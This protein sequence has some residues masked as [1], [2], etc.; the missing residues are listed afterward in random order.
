MQTSMY[1]KVGINM[2]DYI[3]PEI[4]LADRNYIVKNFLS[5]G[6]FATNK[7]ELWKYIIANLDNIDSSSYIKAAFI[8]LAC[9]RIDDDISRLYF[10]DDLVRYKSEYDA[11]A[12]INSIDSARWFFSSAATLSNLLLLNDRVVDANEILDRALPHISS[13]PHTPLSYLNKVYCLYNKALIAI[14]YGNNEEA[15]SYFEKVFVT[16]KAGIDEIFHPLNNYFLRMT[17]D[18]NNLVALATNAS[19]IMNKLRESNDVRYGSRFSLMNIGN[20]K[21]NHNISINRFKKMR[22]KKSDFYLN[23][24]SIINL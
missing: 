24:F 18:I 20:N 17:F 15:I 10:I 13:A 12:P 22:S 4:K 2:S 14:H 19:I 3:I 9:Y 16:S 5:G 21:P 7:E 1:Q 6:G 11:S 8:T 23:V